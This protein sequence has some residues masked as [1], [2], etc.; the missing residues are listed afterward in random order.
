MK[1]HILYLIFLILGCASN[2]LSNNSCHLLFP[3]SFTDLRSSQIETPQDSIIQNQ[4][5]KKNT[6]TISNNNFT[7][8]RGLSEYNS[9]FAIL[10][11]LNQMTRQHR[12]LD[13]GAGRAKAQLDFL[14][15]RQ[16]NQ[17]DSPELVAL[18]VERPWFTV[19]KKKFFKYLSGRK[20]EDYTLSELGKFDLITDYLGPFSYAENAVQILNIYMNVL[21]VGGS[22]K[23]DFNSR[24][25]MI[26]KNEQLQSIKDWILSELAQPPALQLFSAQYN[27]DVLTITRNSEGSFHLPD[28]KLFFFYS[29]LPPVRKYKVDEYR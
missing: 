13:A 15:L 6:K 25:N 24:S 21:N 12:W 4:H 18:S 5:L 17:Q 26:Y 2:A 29:E 10:D 3:D 28:V 7:T 9:R 16:Q 27:N 20:L 19:A 8:S 23:I 11:R 22:I 1:I 14:K